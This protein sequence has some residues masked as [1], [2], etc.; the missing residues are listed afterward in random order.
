[1]HFT[2]IL[3]R[4]IFDLRLSHRNHIEFRY[5]DSIIKIIMIKYVK[6]RKEIWINDVIEEGKP[7]AE[8]RI[9]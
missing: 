7:D 1:M 3:Q 4:G 5:K 6:I 9:S 2:W 8:E